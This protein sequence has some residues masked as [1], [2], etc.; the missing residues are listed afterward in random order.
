MSLSGWGKKA[1]SV[2]FRNISNNSSECFGIQSV[3]GMKVTSK[4]LSLENIWMNGY[5]S[6]NQSQKEK[7]MLWKT[8]K[9]R[10]IPRRQWQHQEMLGTQT[11]SD[12]DVNDRE[13]LFMYSGVD[14][15]ERL[16]SS[17]LSLLSRMWY[18]LFPLC[19]CTSINP[20]LTPVLCYYFI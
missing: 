20:P 5:G 12:F 17:F 15:T 3:H 6:L 8:N 2:L 14:E 1:F 7:E 11:A 16:K 19:G 9:E 18:Y 4:Y 13:L 10:G